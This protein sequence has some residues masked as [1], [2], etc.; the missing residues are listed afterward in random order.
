MDRSYSFI[1]ESSFLHQ[2]PFKYHIA[3]RG[4][5]ASAATMTSSSALP[6][7]RLQPFERSSPLLI[8]ICVLFSLSCCSHADNNSLATYNHITGRFRI[9]GTFSTPIVTKVHAWITMLRCKNI[10]RI[11]FREKRLQS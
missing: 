8:V 3:C 10:W 4:L 2:N 1:N 6:V 7:R 5:S 11:V 9:Q